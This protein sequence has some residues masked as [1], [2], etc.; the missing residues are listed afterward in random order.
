MCIQA[1]FD[2]FLAVQKS[3]YPVLIITKNLLDNKL[4]EVKSVLVEA[5]F[6]CD[7]LG[8]LVRLFFSSKPLSSNFFAL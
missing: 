4:V 3:N 5:V 8:P 7:K 1:N 6:T 2:H